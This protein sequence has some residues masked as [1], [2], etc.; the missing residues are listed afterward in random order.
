VNAVPAFEE[1]VDYD[2]YRDVSGVQL[3][4]RVRTSDGALKNSAFFITKRTWQRLILEPA[5]LLG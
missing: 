1:Q 5:V 2:D 4:F 3:K